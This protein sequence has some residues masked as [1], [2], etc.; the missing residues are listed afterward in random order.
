LSTVSPSSAERSPSSAER[1]GAEL[2]GIAIGG[3][4]TPQVDVPTQVL[5][6][7]P[8]PNPSLLCIL[9]GS[10]RSL[11]APTFAERY[12]TTFASRF[13]T[14]LN[15]AVMAGVILEEDT[16]NATA[17]QTRNTPAAS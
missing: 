15:A 12:G 5:S 14:A 3:I 16:A 8:G 11:P 1:I 7:E 6:G 9:L 17:Q 13:E 10:T 2:L 4:R